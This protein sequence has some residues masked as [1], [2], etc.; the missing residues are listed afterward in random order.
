M[1][2]PEGEATSMPKSVEGGSY[3]SFVFSEGEGEF[4]GRNCQI[5]WAWPTSA[6]GGGF[7]PLS[8]NPVLLRHYSPNDGICEYLFK[9]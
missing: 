8:P 7:R 4:D 9:K 5:G 2:L 3:N 1:Y 6:K